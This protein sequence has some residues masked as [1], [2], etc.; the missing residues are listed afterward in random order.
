MSINPIVSRT[1]DTLCPVTILEQEWNV[2]EPCCFFLV[3]DGYTMAH[4]AASRGHGECLSCL[5]HHGAQLDQYTS[6]RHESVLD[7]GKRSGKYSRI[8][9]ARKIVFLFVTSDGIVIIP[10]L[11]NSSVWKLRREVRQ[12][13]VRSSSRSQC[14]RTVN[15]H[16]DSTWLSFELA[17]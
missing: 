2:T 8:D 14:G 7:L 11:W 16:T 1:G 15:S 5:I 4:L 3:E 10:S 6:D 13:E 17:C 9:Q 12:R